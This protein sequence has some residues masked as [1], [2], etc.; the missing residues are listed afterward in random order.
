MSDLSINEAVDLAESYVTKVAKPFEKVRDVL[1]A[2]IEAQAAV[3][4]SKREIAFL[5]TQI[6]GVKGELARRQA[7]H[8]AFNERAAQETAEI[9]RELDALREHVATV[10][11]EAQ[12]QMN[13]ARTAAA[14][15]VANAESDSAVRK[16]ALEAEVSNLETRKKA[17][18]DAI[19]ALKAGVAAMDAMGGR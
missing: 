10:R 8:D 2:A 4:K 6:E 13:E 16:A 11:N 9:G 5:D 7:E 17:L 12:Q 1:R 18:E 15:V 3:E 19:G 14:I